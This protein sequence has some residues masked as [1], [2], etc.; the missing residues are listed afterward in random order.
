MSPF[1]TEVHDAAAE[2]RA[3]GLDPARLPRHLAIIMDGN[4]RWASRQGWERFF[5]HR[6]GADTVRA[7]TTACVRL[8]IPRLTLYAFSSENWQRPAREVAVLMELLVEYLARELPTLH[9]QQIRLCAIGRLERLP[10][11]AQAALRAAIAATAGYRRMVLTLALSYGGRAE[12]VDACRELA[13]RVAAG[14]LDPE[15]IDEARLGAALYDGEEVDL[16]IRTAGEQRLSNFLLWQT[17]YAEFIS[18]PA[19][20]PEFTVADFHACLREYQR[21]ERRF[22]RV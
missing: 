2:A 14:E 5:G 11:T 21:R 18:H 10:A 7:I 9:E 1:A 20:W 4:G 12:L 16:V 3:A 22:G 8:G 13:R 6:R 19:L 17:A 15:E